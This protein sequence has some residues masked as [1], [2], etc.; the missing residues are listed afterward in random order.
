MQKY[1]CMGIIRKQNSG[2]ALIPILLTVIILAIIA[3]AILQLG[4][5]FLFNQSSSDISGNQQAAIVSEAGIQYA[6]E[7]FED[8]PEWLDELKDHSIQQQYTDTEQDIN[9]IYKLEYR[10]SEGEEP[11]EVVSIGWL[12]D[13]PEITAES[14]ATFTVHQEYTEEVT[15]KVI[16]EETKEE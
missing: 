10:E 16:R 3:L 9:G 5:N 6:I 11:V 14:K 13:N 7:R 1:N 8:N 2:I 12:V 15:E 4:S